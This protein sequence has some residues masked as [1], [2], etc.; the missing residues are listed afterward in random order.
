[1]K[2]V[3]LYVMPDG[4]YPSLVDDWYDEKRDGKTYD[5][6]HPVVAHP[7][8]GP[9]GRLKFLCKYQDPE[10]G[11]RAV[12]QVRKF[13]G[14]LEH[15]QHSSLWKACGLPKPGEDADAFGGYTIEVRQVSWG[16]CCAKPTWL[17]VVGVPRDV[18]LSEVL[19]GGE[20][21][22]RI[23][24]GSRGK[25]HLPRATSKQA[26]ASPPRFAEWLLSIARR[27]AK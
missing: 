2:V 5:G 10:C 6:P 9:W 1:M 13:G 12:E 20:E 11:T 24:N 8:C 15:P 19:T 17:Y 21:T 22:H 4:P 3:A 16:H 26:S 27:V 25:T 23:T 7:P 14:V 18:V